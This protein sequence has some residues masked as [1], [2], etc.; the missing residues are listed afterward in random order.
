ML[1][2]L[3]TWKTVTGLLVWSKSITVPGFD[4]MPLYDVARFF[5]KGIQR[6]ALNEKAAAVA[7]NFFIAIFPCILF[8]FTLLSY[9]PV[10]NFQVVLLSTVKGIMPEKTYEVMITTI[11]D[12]V[13]R[14]RGGLL[15]FSFLMVLY[16]TTRGIKSLIQAFNN[17]YYITETRKWY[18]QRLIALLLLLI[19]SALMIIA[20]TLVIGSQIVLAYLERNEIFRNQLIYLLFG[21]GEWLIVLALYYFGISFLYYFAPA[22]KTHFRF[23]SAGSTLATFLSLAISY[24]FNVYINNFAEYNLLYGSIGTLIL[25]L[26]WIYFHALVLLVGFELNVSIHTAKQKNSTA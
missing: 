9:I 15:S 25:T 4:G 3:L 1:K 22:Q 7:F 17:S 18:A 21:F 19:I 8:F 24:G 16:F 2:K 23:F 14:Q 13:E 6:D 20:T 5:V 12:I 10:E 11:E 26:L